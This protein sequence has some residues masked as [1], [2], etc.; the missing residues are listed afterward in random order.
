MSEKP[1]TQVMNR[2]DQRF[3]ELR[4]RNEKALIPFITAGDPDLATTQELAWAFAEAGADILELGVPFSDPLAD[5]TTIQRASQR[6]LEHGSTLKA[7]IALVERIRD[8]SRVPV[9]LMSYVNPIL[10][11][12]AQEFARRAGSAGVDGVIIPDLPPEEARELP[13]CCE[14]SGVHTIFLAAPTST[15]ARLRHIVEAS[16]GYIYY[17]SLKGVTG[18]R[19]TLE[20]GLERSLTRLRRLTDKPIA[21]GFGISTPAQASTVA[22]LADGVIVGSAI[23]ECIERARGKPR[24]IGE[25]AGFVRTLKEALQ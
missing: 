3:Q 16:R 6:A 5:G 13:G 15:D 25:V 20:A 4:A 1:H 11:M 18:A 22:R 17:V 14:T 23:V 10:R 8:R 7:V 21:V 9:V 19:D 24:M 2:I 12:G